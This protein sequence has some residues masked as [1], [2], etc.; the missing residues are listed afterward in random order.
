MRT[1]GRRSCPR[2]RLHV[3]AEQLVRWQVVWSHWHFPTDQPIH[4]G[5]KDEGALVMDKD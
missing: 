2:R 4:K 3:A 5:V 1:V